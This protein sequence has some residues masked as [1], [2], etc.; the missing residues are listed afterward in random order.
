MAVAA[1]AVTTVVVAE[2]V[3]VV[4][5]MAEEGLGAASA[6]A[7]T[8]GVAVAGTPGTLN[9][10]TTVVLAV[11]SRGCG[12]GVRSTPGFSPSSVVWLT[13]RVGAV[14]GDGLASHGSSVGQAIVPA[15][16]GSNGAKRSASISTESPS[17]SPS[18][19]TPMGA[20]PSNRSDTMLNGSSSGRETGG[21]GALS[22]G[23]IR[24]DAHG[25]T[26][27]GVPVSS[28]LSLS[29]SEPIVFA[30]SV[31]ESLYR[32]SASLGVLGVGLGLGGGVGA[33]IWWNG[34]T[35]SF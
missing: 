29:S 25:A 33:K 18:A 30:T 17:W 14:A 4:A 7:G 24:S 21:D 16:A 26:L 27:L 34:S 2:A 19:G 32:S 23:R 13:F 12:T 22:L 35:G 5:M 15:V 9:A 6:A 31:S 10:A 11:G 20:P 3:V 1:A 8:A 28:S